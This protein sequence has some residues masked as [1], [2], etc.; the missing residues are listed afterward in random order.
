MK[1]KVIGAGGNLNRVRQTGHVGG[2]S[3]VQMQDQGKPHWE[4]DV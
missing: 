1:R 3:V 2:R 4:G